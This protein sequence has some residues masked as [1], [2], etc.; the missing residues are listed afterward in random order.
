M[1]PPLHG[2][3][4]GMKIGLSF[5]TS[6]Q[7]LLKRTSLVWHNNNYTTKPLERTLMSASCLTI[8]LHLHVKKQPAG[9]PDEQSSVYM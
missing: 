8:S 1:L 6:V 7:P 5:S 2:K 3:P 4:K 9:A